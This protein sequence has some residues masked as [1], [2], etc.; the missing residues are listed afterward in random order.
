M[1]VAGEIATLER[2]TIPAL[3]RR[4]LGELRRREGELARQVELASANLRQL[5]SLAI[6]ELR[7]QRDGMEESGIDPAAIARVILFLVGPD[8]RVI[9]GAA[10]PVYGRA[11]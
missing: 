11:S 7:L 10:I 2:H 8:A 9:S 4:L 6:D 1:R 5:P 3:S